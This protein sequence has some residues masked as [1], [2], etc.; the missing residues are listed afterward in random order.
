MIN[1]DKYLYIQD[2]SKNINNEGLIE[3]NELNTFKKA[4]YTHSPIL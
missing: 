3:N 1:H 4:I 2:N